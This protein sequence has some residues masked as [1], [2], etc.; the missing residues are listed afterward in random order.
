MCMGPRLASETQGRS[1]ARQLPGFG[2]SLPMARYEVRLSEDWRG[3]ERNERAPGA[4]RTVAAL[5]RA[6]A[7][8]I[9][10]EGDGL[11]RTCLSGT[12]FLVA[13]DKREFVPPAAFL[14]RKFR[15]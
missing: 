4:R 13:G 3:R 6:P 2:V 9:L 1:E 8:P 11:F 5:F 12:Y 10:K 15:S 7:S 14:W